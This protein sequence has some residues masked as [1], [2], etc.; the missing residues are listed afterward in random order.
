MG[1]ALRE[2]V[3]WRLAVLALLAPAAAAQAPPRL[4]LAQD[5]ARAHAAT[6]QGRGWL[7]ANLSKAGKL[8]IPVLDKCVPEPPDEGELTPFSVYLRLSQKGKV[9]EV[10][11]EIDAE[12]GRC[13]TQE[14]REVQLPLAPREDFWIQVN[15]AT[16]L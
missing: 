11:A 10:V 6:S 14:S 12:L 2:G 8:M 5:L 16:M 13:M 4:K 15:M 1:R 3:L 7:T 9:L